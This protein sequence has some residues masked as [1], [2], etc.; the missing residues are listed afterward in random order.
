M[1][2]KRLFLA[3]PLPAGIKNWLYQLLEKAHL[4]EDKVKK[5]NL[6]ITVY[7]FGSAPEEAIPTLKE[8]I[9]NI[10]DR[11]RRFSFYFNRILMKRNFRKKMLWAVFEKEPSF[12]DLVLDLNKKFNPSFSFRKVVPHITLARLKKDPENIAMLPLELGKKELKVGHV[13]LWESKL[14]PK[15]ATYYSLSK[16]DLQ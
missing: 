5:E 15:G 14:S 3:I 11:H 1:G 2:N 13:E 12:N 4:T 7:F 16:Y 6:H 9:K 10:M 8:D